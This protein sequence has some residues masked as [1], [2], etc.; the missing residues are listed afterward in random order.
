MEQSLLNIGFGNTVVC[1]RV[2][3][4]VSP[5]TAP[6]KRLKDEARDDKRLIDAT[7]G[8]KTRSIIVTDSNHIILSAIQ[9]ETIAQRYEMI[10]G[11]ESPPKFSEK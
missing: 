9:P 2:V 4:I 3:S 1:D 10:R 11:N 7:H 5:N 6:M 8:R